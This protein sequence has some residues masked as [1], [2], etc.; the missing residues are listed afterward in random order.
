MDSNMA[1]ILQ[2]RYILI[3]R[4]T[5]RAEKLLGERIELRRHARENYRLYGEWYGDPE[6]WRL[7]SWA[8][9]PLS[10]SAV[11]R[12]FEDRELSPTDDSFAI[13]LKGEEE[14]VGVISLM[15]ISEANDSAE[16]SVIVG[17]PEDRHQGYGAE[18]IALILRYGFEDL[19]L[20]RVGL[21]VFEFNEDAISTYEKLGFR[22]EGRLRKAV[23]RDDTFHDA[24]LMGISRSEWEAPPSS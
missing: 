9:S 19:G 15:N 17:H 16:L 18:A 22:K 1:A 12:L 20:N 2:S 7:T 14:P 4:P 10:P 13:H 11:E 3:V 21:S 24:I 23:K 6:I 8:A 5:G